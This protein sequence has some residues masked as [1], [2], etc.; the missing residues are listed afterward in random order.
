MGFTSGHFVANGFPT[1]GTIRFQAGP[2]GIPNSNMTLQVLSPTGQSLF[3]GD[4]ALTVPVSALQSGPGEL[5]KLRLTDT[6]TDARTD[7]GIDARNPSGGTGGGG[8]GTGGTGGGS[9]SGGSGGPGGGGDGTGSGSGGGGASGGGAGGGG[10]AGGG[11]GG[12]GA[13]GGAGGSG[14]APG[15]GGGG[16]GDGP[17]RIVPCVDNCRIQQLLDLGR[18]FFNALMAVG[19]IAAVAAIVVAGFQ[20]ISSR[21]DPAALSDAKQKLMYAIVGLL[22]LLFT[23]V[24]VD[25]ILDALKFS[26]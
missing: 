20:Y 6:T 15:A 7:F 24:I 18:N 5:P 16:G 10:A 22:V 25:T 14:N 1:D 19:A 26:G 4:G 17:S 12:G 23:V 21:G 3:R 9:G 2:A 13:G 8:G 11:A